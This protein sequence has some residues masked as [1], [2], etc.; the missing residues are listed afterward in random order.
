MIYIKIHSSY[1]YGIQ[2]VTH[3]QPDNIITPVIHCDI[4]HSA[5]SPRLE[6]DEQ[7]TMNSEASTIMKPSSNSTVP[8]ST[9]SC[10]S[11][12]T[13]K[14]NSEIY[15]AQKY[16]LF[17]IIEADKTIVADVVTNEL[18]IGEDVI[19]CA[20][21]KYDDGDAEEKFRVEYA[22]SSDVQSPTLSELSD[23]EQL[24]EALEFDDTRKIADLF[25]NRLV[26][27]SHALIDI[28]PE[29]N[30]DDKLFK[31]NKSIKI[32]TYDVLLTIRTNWKRT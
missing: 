3:D 6:S 10:D 32:E 23:I 7:P 15:I 30:I 20:I 1:N 8:V 4:L 13:A 17:D 5:L 2:I 12:I 11:P 24:D 26:E 31:D 28:L 25:R 16:V 29:S 19:T 27:K 18:L 22:D 14:S 9:E 21:E